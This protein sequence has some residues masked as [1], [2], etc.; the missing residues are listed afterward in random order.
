MLKIPVILTLSVLLSLPSFADWQFT[1]WGASP[2]E[3]S[4]ASGRQAQPLTEEIAGSKSR[5]NRLALLSMP[6]RSGQFDFTATFLFTRGTNLSEVDLKLDSESDPYALKR[7]LRQKYGT[8][9]R[10]IDPSGDAEWIVGADRILLSSI[11]GK[12]WQLI[13]ESVDARDLNGL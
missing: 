8:P 11:A 12:H 7:A 2:R 6:Y 10:E 9:T 13:Y 3:V 4:D 5:G 1:K